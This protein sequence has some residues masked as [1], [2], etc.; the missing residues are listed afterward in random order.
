ME[1]KSSGARMTST[2]TNQLGAPV[3]P[4]SMTSAPVWPAA[5]AAH[6]RRRWALPPAHTRMA[7]NT[8][9][10]MVC[11]LKSAAR[12]PRRPRT[13]GAE[14]A[15]GL[16]TAARAMSLGGGTKVLRD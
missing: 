16:H 14:S 2:S 8:L 3:R 4:S 11:V 13:C 5:Q 6:L 7:L 1:L 9:P 10:C 12:Q 15:H